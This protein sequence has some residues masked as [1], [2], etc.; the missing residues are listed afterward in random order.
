MVFS[1]AARSL[2]VFLST[3]SARRATAMLTLDGKA[4]KV[5]LS[6]PSAR[7]ATRF[8]RTRVNNQHHFYPRPLRGGR[9]DF[10]FRGRAG[11]C[12]SI[13]ALCEEGDHPAVIV[14]VLIIDFYPR[15]LRGGRRCSTVLANH[16]EK[17]L[18]TPSAR[19][20]TGAV[21]KNFPRRGFLST[22]SARRATER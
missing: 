15:P 3:P 20:A 14:E 17:F 4:Y 12:I 1:R 10:L 9:L 6:T 8:P 21:Q 7:R 11:V 18:S 2:A 5:F 16:C 13:H 22:P 19:R